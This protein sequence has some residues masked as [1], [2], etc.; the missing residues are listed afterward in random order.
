MPKNP[1]WFT[2]AVISRSGKTGLRWD[3]RSGRYELVRPL[4]TVIASGVYPL[5]PASTRLVG[6][7]D[8]V[9]FI[10]AD[11]SAAVVYDLRKERV[12]WQHPCRACSD[13][14][15]SDD[16]LRMSLV[17]ADGLEVWDTRADQLLFREGR[18]VRPGPVESNAL[19]TTASTFSP[20]GRRIAWSH[21]DKVL[22]RE[23]A[24]GQ[25]RTLSLDGA[26]LGF[27][28]NT[29]SDRLLT[30]STRSVSLRDCVTGRTLWNVPNEFA[31]LVFPILWSPDGRS[32]LLVRGFASTE[33]LDATTGERVAWFPTFNRVVTPVR[34][35][36]YYPDVRTKGVA[37]ETT[38]AM[39][40]VPQ[41]D[42]TPPAQS[43]ARTLQ[44][45]GLELRGI[46]L[47]PAP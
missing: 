10:T 40:Q 3:Q 36:Q 5:P 9:A 15:V 16:G 29:E 6:D 22:V 38:W 2:R 31:E 1:L 33:V 13:I 26:L 12:I 11:T 18:R 21:G 25:E 39:R 8:A 47:V 42:E 44:R 37:A 14:A 41:A 23:L 45:T 24:S 32:V 20:D 17:G 46:E 35:E 28:L 27:R 4:D 30:V 43:L 19:G 7:G 34:V